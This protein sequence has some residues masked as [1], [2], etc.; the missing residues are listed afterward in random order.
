MTSTPDRP[1]APASAT[2]RPTSAD[3]RA[4][5][6]HASGARL[7]TDRDRRVHALAIAGFGVAMG[8][9][10]VASRVAETTGAGTG[11]LTALYLGAL[12]ALAGWQKRAAGTIPRN[13]RLIGYVGL[14]ATL[15]LTWVSIIW[16]N[17][18]QGDARRAGLPDQ[19]DSWWVYACAALLTALPM[20]VAGHL[21]DRQRR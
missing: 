15:A 2:G 17:V 19:V 4:A 7:G 1:S 14:G 12:V 9:F 10:V 11:V 13:G 18:R 8:V 6:A 3:A 16:L 5:L 21:I 20:L